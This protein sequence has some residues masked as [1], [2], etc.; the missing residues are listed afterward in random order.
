MN[1]KKLI[2]V[3]KDSDFSLVSDKYLILTKT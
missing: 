2:K 3:S 1:P